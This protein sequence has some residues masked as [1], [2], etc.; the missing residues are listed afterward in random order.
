MLKPTNSSS[1][2]TLMRHSLVSIYL[3]AENTF[4]CLFIIL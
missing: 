3:I 2:L 4:S 1:S